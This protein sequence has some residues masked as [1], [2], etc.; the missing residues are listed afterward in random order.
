MT[1]K[2]TDEGN[3]LDQDQ[4][5]IIDT[6]AE[7]IDDDPMIA[8]MKEAEAEIAALEENKGET[9]EDPEDG[10][11]DP[12]GEE[13][14]DKGKSE[15]EPGTEAQ[16]GDDSNPIMI[17]KGRFDEVLSKNDLLRDQLG[18]TSGKLD[19]LEKELA[20]LKSQQNPPSG[21]QQTAQDSRA[22]DK[23]GQGVDNI[24]AMISAAEAKKLELAEKYDE[25]EMSTVDLRK[26]EIE[27]DKDIR[28]LSK[29][30]LEK[31]AED[32]KAHTN[33]ALN[34]TQQENFVHSQAEI[35]Q[36]DHPNIEA[37]D[38]LPKAVSQAVWQSVN[39]QAVQN[40]TQRG[41]DV[42]NGSVESR[43][44]I[45][46]EKAVLTD[47]LTPENT[48]EFLLG[49]YKF[50]DPS[51]YKPEQTQGGQ[52][53]ETNDGKSG[54]SEQAKNRAN[55]LDLAN[56]QPPSTAD[57]G[58]GTSTGELTDEAV[59][60]MSDDQMADLIAKGSPLVNRILGNSAV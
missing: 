26:A 14:D 37:I 34:A 18:Y 24:D 48:T 19:A 28:E 30:R 9:E 40:L 52:T 57:M 39:E 55:K 29:Q 60:N 41:V 47:Q 53:T 31:V 11:T 59:A 22:D 15:D 17:P 58:S 10:T 6:D 1:D 8:E 5:Q 42:T 13:G 2:I 43:L 12:K 45:I 3:N 21:D 16:T 27:I 32:S 56:E 50:V 23:E 25:G 36:K 49:K 35:I 33:A 7:I 44:A 46:K 38:A 51:Q 20:D 54:I 4:D